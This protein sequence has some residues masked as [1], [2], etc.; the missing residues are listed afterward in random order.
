MKNKEK[1]AKE[2]AEI[3]IRGNDVAINHDGIPVSCEGLFSCKKCL[4]QI[5]SLPC[6][7]ALKQWAE[8]E[9]IE[10]KVFTKE[11]KEILKLLQ[12]VNWV[13]KDKDGSVYFYYEKPCKATQTWDGSGF[14]ISNF[15]NVKFESVKWDDPEPTSREE[16]LK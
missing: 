9:Y 2:I 13:A 1:F 7:E 11:E 12:K 6:Y 4:L 3:A 15:S 10:Q 14:C 16:I 8:T 5:Q